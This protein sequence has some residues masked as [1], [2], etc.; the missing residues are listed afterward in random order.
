MMIMIS[1]YY[2]KS[3]LS[4]YIYFY[5][6]LPTN[7]LYIRLIFNW[8]NDTQQLKLVLTEILINIAV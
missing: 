7:V 2:D 4:G 8:Q 6:K 3:S 1:S 5:A